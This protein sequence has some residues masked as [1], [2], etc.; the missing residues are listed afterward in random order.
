M[1]KCVK[2]VVGC[3]MLVGI[4]KG[5]MTEGLLL[6]FLGKLAKHFLR[7][8]KATTWQQSLRLTH[9]PPLSQTETFSSNSH[10]RT[11]FDPEIRFKKNH[12][13]EG[14]LPFLQKHDSL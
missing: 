8:E 5:V 11:P 7:H 13:L 6:I 10:Q 1:K 12:A 4:V 3:H 9:F 14:K 2:S